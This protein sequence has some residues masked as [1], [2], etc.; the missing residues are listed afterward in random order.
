MDRGLLLWRGP[1]HIRRDTPRALYGT[2]CTSVSRISTT[3][4]ASRH[5]TC[6]SCHRTCSSRRATLPHLAHAHTL[7][8][9]PPAGPGSG[10]GSW[11]ERG[12]R[13]GEREAHSSTHH[14]R[15][16]DFVETCSPVMCACA[17][18][19]KPYSAAGLGP[20]FIVLLWRC[21]THVPPRLFI[22]FLHV[23]T[24]MSASPS[25]RSRFTC[26]FYFERVTMAETTLNARA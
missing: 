19:V 23:V 18:S 13:A 22:G 17:Y 3:T 25:P 24:C 12:R 16:S 8:S 5:R 20:V 7:S 4:T 11:P 6:V 9:G 26:S 21:S 15:R 14:P 2:E 1:I 10:V